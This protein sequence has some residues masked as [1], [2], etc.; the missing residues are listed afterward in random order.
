MRRLLRVVLPGL[1][2]ACGV[3]SRGQQS[4][5]EL[6]HAPLQ[7]GAQ[8]VLPA[9]ADVHLR[10]TRALSSK[11]AKAGDIVELE[12]MRDV[13][14]DD[15]LVIPRHAPALAAVAAAQPSRRLS[16]GGSIAFDLKSVKIITGDWVPIRATKTL[17]GG[18]DPV[19]KDKNV[20]DSGYLLFLPV[21]LL[22]G[23]EAILPRG[24][25]INAVVGQ[26]VP[27]DSVRLRDSITAFE[28]KNAPSRSTYAIAHIYRHVPDVS[29]GKPKIYLDGV[30]L[31]RMQGDRYLNIVVDPG[32]HRLRT[33][34][35]EIIL[36][37]KAGEEY[38]LRVERRGLGVFSPPKAYL[39][40]VPKERG[41][42]EIYAL[43]AL[44]PTDVTDRSKLAR[45]PANPESLH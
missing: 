39:E 43:E 29:G 42:D 12:V 38:Y 44:N 40:L 24:T 6:P 35:S 45:P 34:K 31:A 23:E 4:A 19:Q 21:I 3:S 5:S 10:T 25:E 30:E 14:V 11:N 36:D 27:I 15:F 20:L 9:N 18:P 37:C 1:A 8:T 7:P 33:D 26:E 28:T 2:L 22:R 16:R 13:K 41:E 32:E 17:K